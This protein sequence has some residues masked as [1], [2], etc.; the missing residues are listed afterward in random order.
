MGEATAAARQLGWGR[1]MGGGGTL[2]L[3]RGW[4][5]LSSRGCRGVVGGE[6]RGTGGQGQFTVRGR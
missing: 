1:Q 4:R 6:R 5:G 2:S 3:S